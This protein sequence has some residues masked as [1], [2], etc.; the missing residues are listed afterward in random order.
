[1][2]N[3]M[4]K[5]KDKKVV[6]KLSVVAL[7]SAAAASVGAII[8]S[9]SAMVNG[10]DEKPKASISS[11]SLTGVG[12]GSTTSSA[13]SEDGAV[14]SVDEGSD[15][16]ASEDKDVSA[17][18]KEAEEKLHT[19]LAKLKSLLDELKSEKEGPEAITKWGEVIRLRNIL[20]DENYCS[21]DIWKANEDLIDSVCK[22][23]LEL[24]CYK[25]G[26]DVLFSE[27]VI[28]SRLFFGNTDVNESQFRV[29]MEM[30][31]KIMVF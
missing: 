14:L 15:L 2:I 28:Q 10:E 6:M 5:L 13:I 4:E 23:T 9:A 1:M 31:K 24:A 29:L 18:D 17:P 27:R 11:D 7:A 26:C 12:T 16:A 21:D 22:R 25:A 3:I 8:H 30:L 19:D 20:M